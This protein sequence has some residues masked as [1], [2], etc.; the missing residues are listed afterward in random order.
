[1]RIKLRHFL[2]S[3]NRGLIADSETSQKKGVPLR[4]L[5]LSGFT[6]QWEVDLG[7]VDCL[8]K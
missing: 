4:S 8:K 7:V 6:L 2:G 5:R 3:R 1:M